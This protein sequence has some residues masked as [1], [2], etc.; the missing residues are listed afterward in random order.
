MKQWKL[1]LFV[2]S[3]GSACLHPG[4]LCNA[5]SKADT[6]AGPPCTWNSTQS[7]P[8]KLCGPAITNSMDSFITYFTFYTI[9]SR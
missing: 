3:P 5:V 6:T 4:T 8:V 2:N 1:Y 7:S 9:I